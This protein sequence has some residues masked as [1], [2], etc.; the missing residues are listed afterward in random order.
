MPHPER[1][2]DDA[3]GSEAGLRCSSRCCGSWGPG[4]NIRETYALRA[5]GVEYERILELMGR[6]PNYL[7]LSLFSVMWS[8]HC[9]YKNSRPSCAASRTRG[10]GSCRGRGRTRGL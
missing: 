6:E 1:V 4:L 9:G 5:L 8:E 3:L 2:S 7:E 10:R